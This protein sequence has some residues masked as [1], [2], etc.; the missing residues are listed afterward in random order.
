[1]RSSARFMKDFY[2]DKRPSLRTVRK[3]AYKVGAA[4]LAAALLL[5]AP[6]W[7]ETVSGR[8]ALEPL[9]R[10]T[11]RSIVPGQ[12]TEVLVGEGTPVVEGTPLFVLRNVRIEG[13]ADE[14]R[15][16]LTAAEAREREA[17]INDASLGSARAERA[18]QAGGFRSALEQVGA[19]RVASPIAG[20]VST[21]RLRDRVG[22][23]V[24]AGDVLAEVDD[25]RMFKARIFIPEFQVRKI[26]LGAPVSLKLEGLF[27]P[28][29]GQV[30]SLAPSSSELDRGL[31]PKDKYQGMAPPS[32]YAASVLL[33]NVDGRLRSGMSGEAKIEVRR[34]S[35]AGSAWETFRE[36]LQRKVW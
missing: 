7:R 5:F 26:T 36:F 12:I 29:R 35:V 15:G 33:S 13:E 3:Q 34:Q 20:V 18:S 19:L 10:E 17:L 6:I 31:E 9:R 4:V 30:S 21:P 14:A 27:R 11:I 22:S 23:F 1:L 25:A 24:E 16:S 32:Y 2:L 8:F 28:V